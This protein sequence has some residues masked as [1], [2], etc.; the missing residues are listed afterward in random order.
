MGPGCAGRVHAAERNAPLAAF[1]SRVHGCQRPMTA[2]A[3]S[4]A[5]AVTM[6]AAAVMAAGADSS[7]IALS[8]GQTATLAPDTASCAA[9]PTATVDPAPACA[10]VPLPLRRPPGPGYGGRRRRGERHDPAGVDRSVVS[11]V[12]PPRLRWPAVAAPQPYDVAAGPLPPRPWPRRAPPH[13]SRRRTSH[14]WSE[15]GRASRRRVARTSGCPRGRRRRSR[16]QLLE[17]LER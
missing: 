10:T 9:T 8:S 5:A 1:D 2:V 6:P 4:L 16:P 15:C 3:T 13:P 11:H 14:R 17:Q 7:W 12:S